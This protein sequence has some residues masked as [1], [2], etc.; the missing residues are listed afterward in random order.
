M[1]RLLVFGFL[2]ALL[3]PAVAVGQDAFDGT[4]KVDINKAQMPTKPDVY[5]LQDGMYH[6]KTCVPPIDVKADGTDQM[7]TGHP[8]YDSISVKVVDDH[9]TM[10]TEKKDGKVVATSKTTVSADGSTAAFEFSDS[11]ATNADPVTGKGKRCEWR[12]GRLDRMPSP[13]RGD[14]RKWRTCQIT[15]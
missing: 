6:C 3:L 7:V 8:Y 9:T 14:S 2:L 1:K 11:S 5:L 12:A 10:E 15:G 4:W 13:G